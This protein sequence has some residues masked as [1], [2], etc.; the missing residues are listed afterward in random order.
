VHKD[1]GGGGYFGRGSA[2]VVV[3]SDEGGALAILGAKGGR[4]EAARMRAHE[5]D[6]RAGPACRRERAGRAV[7]AGQRSWPNGG[8]R[9]W[10]RP[11]GRGKGSGPAWV[12]ERR[13]AAGSN[14]EPGQISKRN[15]F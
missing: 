15:S 8:W 7:F 5:E 14:P 2:R 4:R 11:N 12:K 1:G 9:W 10:R 3:G 6:D 13:A